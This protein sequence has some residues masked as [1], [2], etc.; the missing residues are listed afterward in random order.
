MQNQ[1]K[2]KTARLI[3]PPKPAVGESLLLSP[4][5]SAWLPAPK[6]RKACGD[7]SAVTWWRWRNDPEL[8]FPAGKVIRGRWYFPVAAVLE[9]W[10]NQ[11]QQRRPA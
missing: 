8:N 2:I 3:R 4:S 1:K 9:W 5:K 10:R 11:P 6:L 7:V